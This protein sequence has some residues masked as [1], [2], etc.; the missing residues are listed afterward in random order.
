MASASASYY[1]LCLQKTLGFGLVF[2]LTLSGL[3]LG[4][5]LTSSW[6]RDVTCS[7]VLTVD[8]DAS[9]GP[10]SGSVQ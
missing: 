1:G 8:A 6:P 9:A 2:G 3:G 5:G 4:L 10:D 7:V